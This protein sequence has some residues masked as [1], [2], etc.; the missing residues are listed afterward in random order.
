MI[1]TLQPDLGLLLVVLVLAVLLLLLG[2][3]EEVGLAAPTLH[4]E[5]QVG[6]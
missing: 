1:A 3:V 2:K 5:A 6:E 4:P